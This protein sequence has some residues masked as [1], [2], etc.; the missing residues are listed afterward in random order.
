VVGVRSDGQPLNAPYPQGTTT[1]TWTATDQAG[2]QA[3]CV[4][5]VQVTNQNPIVTITGPPSGS[6]Y[7]I[8]SAVNFT[9]T[10]SDTGGT[11]TATW[12]FT[13]NMN[14]FSQAGV[15]NESTGAI[16]AT[17]TFNDAGV[18]LV[19]LTVTDGCGGT[20]TADTVDGLTAMVLS[21]TRTA[22]L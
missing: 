21:M 20:G 7:P 6:I 2:N 12:T 9:G 13:S 11:H 4:Q 19:K 14:S 18:Y 3:S 10:F 22:A 5:T 17:F 1:I 16:T 15:V 8:G